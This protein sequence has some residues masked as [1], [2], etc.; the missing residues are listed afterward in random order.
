MGVEQLEADGVTS[1]LSVEVFDVA[2]SSATP[3][4]GG[5]DTAVTATQGVVAEVFEVSELL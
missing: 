2:S 4:R 5:G 1:A 3:S